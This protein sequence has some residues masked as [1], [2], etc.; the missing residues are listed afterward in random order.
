MLKFGKKY[1]VQSCVYRKKKKKKKKKIANGVT[2][3]K[4]KFMWESFI[5]FFFNGKE[6][7]LKAFVVRNA[8]N[9]FGSNCMEKFDLFNG[10]INTF[11]NKIV[12]TTKSSDKLKKKEL[13]IKFLEI[14]SEGLWF[15]SKD[16]VKFK[17]KEHEMPYFISRRPVPYASVEIIDKKT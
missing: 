13:K 1:S 4:L 15:C 14:F 17:V 9:L 16:K 11:C 2:G 10:P 12:D 7:K 3:E 8:Q 5:I 6:R